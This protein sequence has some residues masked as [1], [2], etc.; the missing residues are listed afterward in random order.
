MLTG[1]EIRKVALP[2][3]S[4]VGHVGYAVGLSGFLGPG[5]DSEAKLYLYPNDGK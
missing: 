4:A 5:P 2:L 1:G 3:L